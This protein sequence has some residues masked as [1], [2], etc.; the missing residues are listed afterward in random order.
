MALVL[1]GMTLVPSRGERCPDPPPLPRVTGSPR[2]ALFLDRDGTINVDHGY[3]GTRDR[4]EWVEGALDAIR[5]A[6]RAGWHVFVVT[7]QSGVARGLFDEAAVD[8]LHAWMIEEIRAAG[9][10]VDD[11]LYCPFHEDAVVPRYRRASDWRK[12]APG[13]VLE[14]MRR[15]SL[16]PRRCVL[17]GDQPRD[18]AAAEAAGIAGVLF[19]GGSLADLVEKLLPIF[20]SSSPPGRGSG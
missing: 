1:T 18:I 20:Q 17:V 9:G 10:N 2:P 19:E 7:N 5:M 15:W 14:L 3:V 13:M 16:D 11:V 4:F 8:A 12:P 6:T